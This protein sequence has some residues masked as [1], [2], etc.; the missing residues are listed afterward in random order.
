MKK[1]AIALF[2]LLL[3]IL[4]A[5]GSSDDSSASGSEKETNETV[6]YESETGAVEVPADPKRVV[7]LASY[8]GNVEALGVDIVGVDGWAKKSPVLAEGLEDAETVTEDDVEK[9][10]ELKP[11]LII[12]A[13]TTKNLDKFKEIAP[14]VTYTYNKLDYLAQHVEIGKLLNKE[15]EAQKQV[16][17]YKTRAK[18]VG[19]KI[20]AKIGEDTTVTVIEKYEKGIGVLGD[21]WG[22]G[23]EVLYQAMGLKMPE[24]TKE[25]TKKDGYM[26]IS[27]EVLADYV[28]DY[29]VTSQYSD[30]DNS[31]QESELF[32]EIPAVK[33]GH[34]LKA[35]ANAFL[36]N[37]PLT[38]EYQVDFFEE[39][40][41]K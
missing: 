25:V 36:F 15:E 34:L 22:R 24:K 10:L 38:L 11:D 41:L 28:G 30:Q 31:Y 27:E 35:D 6:T 16:D 8:A 14:T 37:D 9:I 1:T 33:E 32:K 18:E 4:S 13:S 26:M 23:T 2:G 40:F 7:V 19:D 3:L 17:D 20:K 5:C 12:G 29:L 21:S 39:E